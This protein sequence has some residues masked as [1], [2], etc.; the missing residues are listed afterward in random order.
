MCPFPSLP[1]N[2]ES[3]TD[4]YE[5]YK[6]SYDTYLQYKDSYMK[7]SQLTRHN[8][9]KE[10]GKHKIVPH[11]HIDEE[12]TQEETPESVHFVGSILSDKPEMYS[13]QKYMRRLRFMVRLKLSS[14]KP[15]YFYE[16]KIKRF[17]AIL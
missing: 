10:Y 3:Y 13:R 4:T 12:E 9:L 2:S 6:D 8:Y 11:I 7:N 1:K 5:K 15:N 16:V 17:L 14:G